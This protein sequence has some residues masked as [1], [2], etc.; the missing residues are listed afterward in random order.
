MVAMSAAA[1]AMGDDVTGL[2]GVADVAA[3]AVGWL[4]PCSPKLN[5]TMLAT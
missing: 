2:A 4:R 1:L 3:L 5:R